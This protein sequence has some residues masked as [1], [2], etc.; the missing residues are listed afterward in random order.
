MDVILKLVYSAVLL[1]LSG[2]LI[3]E[4]WTVWADPQVYV[5]R[6]EVVSET[7]E[8]SETGAIFAKRIVS[9]QAVMA[10]QI[11]E[12]QSRSGDEAPTDATYL[13][14]GTEFLKLP[15][16]ALEGIDITIQ[17]VNVRELM[18][19]VRKRFRAPNEVR[20]HVT[21]REG[22]VLTAVDWPR[23]PR[24]SDGKSSMAQFITP[25]RPTAQESAAYVACSILYGRASAAEP[26]ISA[27]SRAQICDFAT[28]LNDLYALGATASQPA[29]LTADESAIVRMRA[30]QLRGHYGSGAVFPELYRLRADLLDLLPEQGRTQGELVDAQEDRL[31]YAMLSPK[32]RDLPEEEKR[33]T[34]LALARPAV[35]LESPLPAPDNW[36]RIL[37]RHEAAV[38]A[39]AASTGLLVRADGMPVGTGFIVA[40]GLVMTA[41][42][43]LDQIKPA[44]G[45]KTTVERS[46]GRLCLGVSAEK[47]EPALSIGADLFRDEAAQI[48]IAEL[49]DHDPIDHPP[50]PLL[51][52]LPEA[53]TLTGRYAFVVGYPFR[54]AR[55]PKAF[56]DRLL[57]KDEG[58]KRV[59]P[60][61]IL[62]FGPDRSGPS[63]VERNQS[64][65]FTTDMS[66]SG[67]TGGAPLVDI[68]TGTV[69]AVSYAGMWRGERGKF[70]YARPIPSAAL[71]LVNRRTR[72]ETDAGAKPEAVKSESDRTK[73]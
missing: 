63:G 12:Y 52:P 18:N 43:V 47:C 16:E 69:M 34:A 7:G 42:F 8:G 73:R 44:N 65:V 59:I 28:G 19:A 46:S 54:D 62:A 57:G 23:A 24:I 66:T 15:P 39:T 49:A 31:R 68:S 5:G 3:R 70:S 30:R 13:M 11:T 33:F 4:L 6:F 72:G 14:P 40:P 56:V 37:T 36:S 2:I 26:R 60:G 51:A 29:G 17:N 32:L 58:R 1:G 50:L 10:R 25:S 38:R 67:G 27:F 45:K 20:G 64:Q 21:M 61:R 22:S 55:M 9:G 53:N 35:L 41:T 48:A 71:E